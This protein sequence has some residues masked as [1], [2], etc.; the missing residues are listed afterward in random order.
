MRIFTIACR[1]NTIK[2]ATV[3]ADYMTRD[4]GSPN[5]LRFWVKGKRWWNRR[6]MVA[7]FENAHGWIYATSEEASSDVDFLKDAGVKIE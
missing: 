3:R 2:R 7:A 4:V 5:T 1:N 6:R